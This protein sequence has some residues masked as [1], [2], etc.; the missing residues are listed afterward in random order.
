MVWFSINQ[1]MCGEVVIDESIK[2]GDM[3]IQSSTWKKG[4]QWHIINPITQNDTRPLA[5]EN[6]SPELLNEI[7]NLKTSNN[8]LDTQLQQVQLEAL[9]KDKQIENMNKKYN[10]L[11]VQY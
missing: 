7:E 4:Q 5:H 9:N 11:K 6:L 10:D 2:K 1:E 3:Y 8:N